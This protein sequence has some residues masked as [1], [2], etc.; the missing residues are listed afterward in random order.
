MPKCVKFEEVVGGAGCMGG[1]DKDGV[2]PGRRQSF[3]YQRR[4]VDDCSSGRGGMAQDSGT[5]GG[6]FHG[7]ID[8]C[9]ESY[10]GLD[11]GMQ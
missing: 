2:F 5:T 11:Y 6:T 10:V 3:R 8:R 4:L 7:E 9:R 1:Q